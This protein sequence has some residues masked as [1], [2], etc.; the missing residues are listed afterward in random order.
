M[1]VGKMIN[2]LNE[3]IFCVQN[4]FVKANTNLLIFKHCWCLHTHQLGKFN[5]EYF[6]VA[7]LFINSIE[8]RA[9]DGPYKIFI[10]TYRSQFVW[11]TSIIVPSGS[12]HLSSVKRKVLSWEWTLLILNNNR[13]ISGHAA[14]RFNSICK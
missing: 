11:W 1:N 5:I 6:H 14:Q 12:N 3:A 7:T 4:R 13:P 2:K 8:I 10:Q 9:S